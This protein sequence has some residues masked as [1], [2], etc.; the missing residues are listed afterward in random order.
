ML[1][2][3]K[4]KYMIT[5]LNIFLG[6]LSFVILFGRSFTGIYIIN[7]RIGELMIALCLLVSLVILFLP[8]SNSFVKFDKFN[9]YIHK[10]IVSHFIIIVFLTNTSFSNPYTYK[11]SSYVWTLSFLYISLFITK[12]MKK[13]SW[14]FKLFPFFLPLLYILSTIKFPQPLIDFFLNYSDKFDFV[15]ASDL[16]IIYIATNFILRLYYKNSLKD[17]S[18]FII[19]S[20]VYLPYLL[21]KSKGAFFPSVIFIFINFLFY[22]SV[23]KKEKIKSLLLLTLSIPL[24]FISTFHIYG[25]LNFTKEGMENYQ[26]I[27]NLVSGQIQNS[28][29]S[30][31]NEKNTGEILYSFYIMDGRL[32]SKEQMADW[33][34]QIWQDIARDLFWESEYFEGSNYELIR[35]Q[36][37][38]RNDIFYKG[39]GYKEL[40]PSMNHWERQGTDGTNENPH[41]FLFNSLGR[42]GVFQPILIILFHLSIFIY[43]YK[44]YKNFHIL[45]F[46]LPVLL[47]SSFDASMESVRFP[48]V[49]YSFLGLILNEKI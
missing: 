32:Y 39:F 21:F 15:K 17:F 36:G 10:L 22:I 26:Q 11:S 18:Y 37:E 8:F 24:F 47:T 25:N 4:D 38:R 49:Y 31:V 30:L 7:Y 23:I 46:I 29:S 27:D 34:L 6:I 16:L 5:I 35:I 48:F 41:N 1:T 33:R 9:F 20:A 43:W 14:F 42:G 12:N 2:R 44:K 19:S 45:L 13:D 28:L 3:D 40:L